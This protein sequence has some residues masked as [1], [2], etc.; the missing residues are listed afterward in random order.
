MRV[1]VL[2]KAYGE[3]VILRDFVME[4]GSREA[5]ALIGPS[6]IGKSTLL[7]IIAGLDGAYEGAVSGAGRI[8]L[9]FQEPT[10][11]PWRSVRDN[12]TLTTRCSRAEADALLASVGLP[13]IGERFPNTLSLGQARRVS[14]ARAFAMRPDT[15]LLDEPFASLDRDVSAKMQALLLD[16]LRAHPAR[17]I[18]VT[19]DRGE[20]ARLATRVLRLGG[21]PARIEAET[22][23]ETPVAARDEAMIAKLAST[24]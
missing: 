1:T 17:L 22:P 3:T 15:L 9:A 18:L 7:R 20:A 16:L 14:L 11:L 12:L 24:L 10:L 19:H 13:D 6:G 2:R 21:V 5:V 4:V 8:A 23:L